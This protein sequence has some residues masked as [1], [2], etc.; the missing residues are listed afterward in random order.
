MI[1]QRIVNVAA[2]CRCKIEEGCTVLEWQSPAVL[3]LKSL[4]GH[5]SLSLL[6]ALISR[7]SLWTERT[8]GLGTPS[9]TRSSSWNTHTMNT[10]MGKKITYTQE[11]NAP[12]RASLV[13]T[14]LSIYLSTSC[15]HGCVTMEKQSTLQKEINHR[16]YA[17]N[18][19]KRG[20]SEHE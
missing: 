1:L 10:T 3:T 9:E 7:Y 17:K 12:N 4:L 11:V 18:E 19:I 8:P 16:H 13:F 15:T 14:Y 6:S 2:Y 5:S 20:R